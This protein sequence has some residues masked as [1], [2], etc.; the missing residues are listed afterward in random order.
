MWG[1][2]AAGA[3]CIKRAATMVPITSDAPRM[4][5]GV[6]FVGARL[7]FGTVLGAVAPPQACAIPIG[8]SWR[9]H[10]AAARE[11]LCR[12]APHGMMD[13]LGVAVR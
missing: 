6:L 7:K 3:T 9:G 1:R 5:L 4:G 11:R 13:Q 12:R 10:R 8:S 2:C